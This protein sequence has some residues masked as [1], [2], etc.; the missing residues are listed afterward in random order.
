M[1]NTITTQ[2]VKKQ[3]LTPNAALLTFD[4][5]DEVAFMRYLAGQYLRVGVA[6]DG[7]V[8]NRAYSICNFPKAPQILVKR[9]EGGLVSNYI[10]DQLEEGDTLEISKPL[11]DFVF[12]KSSDTEYFAIAAGSGITPILSHIYDALEQGAKVS[13]FYINREDVLLENTIEA[14]K[15]QYADQFSLVY[16]NSDKDGRPSAEQIVSY[17]STRAE[18]LFCVPYA[19]QQELLDTLKSNGKDDSKVHTEVFFAPESVAT[20][21]VAT[22]SDTAVASTLSVDEYG[23]VH[24]IQ[25]EENQNL[26]DGMLKHTEDIDISFGC[27]GGVCGSCKC[28]LEE[29]SVHMANHTALFDDE[30]EE[31]YILVCQS[32]ATSPEISISIE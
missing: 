23:D 24:T 16:H 32:V 7:K 12:D 21:T 5:K 25:L 31:G 28:K 2:L 14:L 19:L 1:S 26:L 18:V 22:S 3:L 29:G 9:V 17:A 6:I 10:L 27:K 8:H 4:Y 15:S 13:L 30:I 11:G 20:V